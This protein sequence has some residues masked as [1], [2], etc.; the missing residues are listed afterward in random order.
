MTHQLKASTAVE[1]FGFLD[2]L[3]SSRCIGTK[4]LLAS[5]YCINLLLPPTDCMDQKILCSQAKIASNNSPTTKQYYCS[6][7]QQH[8]KGGE[9]TG[10]VAGPTVSKIEVNKSAIISVDIEHI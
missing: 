8:C 3:F 5:C 10:Q 6:I 9:K 4:L 7:S 2:S 1:M